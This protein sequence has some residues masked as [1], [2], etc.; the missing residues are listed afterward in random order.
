MKP[1][2]E[3][4]LHSRKV[5][6]KLV[7]AVAVLVALHL[8]VM[9][10][11]FGFGHD[12][13]M[14]MARVFDLNEESNVPTWYSG[15]ALLLCSASL[16]LVAAVKRRTHDRFL[17]HWGVLALIFAYMSLDEVSRFHEH[18]GAFLE[19]PFAWARRVEVAGGIFRNLWVVPAAIVVA[20]IGL[21]YLRFLWSLPVRTRVQFILAGVLFVWASVGMEMVGAHYTSIGGRQLVGFAVLVTIEE[22]LEMGSIVFFLHAVLEY[23][24]QS[25]GSIRLLVGAPDRSWEDRLGSDGADR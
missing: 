14:G 6:L 20:I 3:L 9:V 4:V 23:I 24:A 21:A 10:A 22:V 13:L 15:V 7:A 5:V 2:V 1:T 25:L 17:A 8:V 12:H 18:W 19:V 16:A 11:K